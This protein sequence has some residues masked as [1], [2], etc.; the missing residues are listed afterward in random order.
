MLETATMTTWEIH[1]AEKKAADKA[2]WDATVP[3]AEDTPQTE[4]R[5]IAWRTITQHGVGSSGLAEKA[6]G[7]GYV[8]VNTVF[9]LWA[10]L[11][12]RY[13]KEML[14][15]ATWHGALQLKVLNRKYYKAEAAIAEWRQRR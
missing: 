7:L 15:E 4:R 8:E 14:T 13:P 12:G 6:S 1:R 2:L 9:N 11:V 5:D 3:P 10:H